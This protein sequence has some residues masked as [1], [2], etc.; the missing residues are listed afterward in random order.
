MRKN[1]KILAFALFALSACGKQAAVQPDVPMSFSAVPR[2]TEQSSQT[3]AA[4]DFTGSME[5]DGQQFGVYAT[6]SGV[7]VFRNQPQAV[8]YYSSDPKGWF[9]YV[10]TSYES[11]PTQYET[12]NR[13]STYKFRAWFP[14]SYSPHPTSDSDLVTF[15]GFSLF[16]DN[17][18]L[19]VAYQERVPATQGTGAV[20]LKFNHAL[21]AVQFEVQYKEGVKP[22]DAVDYVTSAWLSGVCGTGTFAFGRINSTDA[23]DNMQWIVSS[24]G[25]RKLHE[26]TP[27]SAK[28]KPFRV[29]G[30]ATAPAANVYAGSDGNGYVFA[31]PQSIGSD[32]A[33]NF[34]TEA[35]GDAVFSAKLLGGTLPTRWECGKKYTYTISVSASDIEVNVSIKPWEE[36]SS[37]WDVFI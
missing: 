29:V 5:S 31:I 13:G 34:T 3:R 9:Y 30:S 8:T 10:H 21:A 33:F 23:V 20:E 28:D 7:D 25:S 35:S 4:A 16:V 36:L 24:P 37:G 18:D 15:D 32:A 14:Y 6:R 22:A 26:W 27:T 12:W 17:F 19:M 1:I 11:D 2:Q